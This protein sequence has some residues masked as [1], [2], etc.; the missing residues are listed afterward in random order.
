MYKRQTQYPVCLN[1]FN[2]AGASQ[3]YQAVT[4]LI[5][6]MRS[7]FGNE[8]KPRLEHVFRYTAMA[9]MEYPEANL[10]SVLEMLSHTDFR[11][12]VLT[13][14]NDPLVLRFFEFEFPRL[15]KKY[16]GTVIIPLMNKIG[17]LVTSPHI[18]P[19]FD[20]RQVSIDFN[21]LIA[22][23][24]IILVHI[25]KGTIGEE[26]ARFLGALILSQLKLAGMRRG[27]LPELERPDF[28]IYVD[29]FHTIITETFEQFLAESRRYGFAFTIAHQYVWQLQWTTQQAVLGTVGTLIVFR[30]GSDDAEK[31]V[32]ELEPTFTK[33]DMTGL[34]E[35][36]F[37]IKMTIDGEN[38]DPFSAETL[39][40]LPSPE[41]SHAKDIL[42]YSRMCY[43]CE[44]E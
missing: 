18:R 42:Q 12:K 35:S 30:I 34:G 17:Q 43:T 31:L 20:Q 14:S 44:I 32:G 38:S 5:D 36:Q 16:E 15:Q 9:L 21:E 39:R 26:N 33:K 4:G 22:E 11:N 37:Y 2:I 8:W 13:Y 27:E 41:G 6:V 25:A 19:L 29:E 10:T 40:V 28:Y 3:K 23:K 24:K 1:P 7:F